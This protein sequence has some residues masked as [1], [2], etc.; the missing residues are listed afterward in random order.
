MIKII[1]IAVILVIVL[2]GVVGWFIVDGYNMTPQ[3][4][5]DNTFGK[6]DINQD[7]L[8]VRL[9]VLF[10]RLMTS[11]SEERV[12]NG[13]RIRTM[14]M[15][16]TPN[17]RI[18]RIPY[19]VIVDNEIRLAFAFDEDGKLLTKVSYPKELAV[20]QYMIVRWGENVATFGLYLPSSGYPNDD[21]VRNIV[22]RYKN[23]VLRDI[24]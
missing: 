11:R 13:Y 2:M 21:Q 8:K 7:E 1:V 24:L 15:G 23:Y 3:K 6:Q 18:W 16:E 5:S 20:L 17:K 19:I 10:I 14:P 12:R 4:L 9:K 22:E